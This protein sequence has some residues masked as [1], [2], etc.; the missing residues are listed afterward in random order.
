MERIKAGEGSP[1]SKEDFGWRPLL[2][3]DS[4]WGEAPTDDMK[5]R[6]DNLK[7]DADVGDEESVGEGKGGW[8]WGRTYFLTGGSGCFLGL[9][10]GIFNVV[11]RH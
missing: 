4:Q 6:L 9:E 3:I 2:H 10:K 8:A 7:V 5:A 1:L 11:L